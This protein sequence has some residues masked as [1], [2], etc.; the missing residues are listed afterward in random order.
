VEYTDILLA[1]TRHLLE[2]VRAADPTPVVSWLRDRVKALE[3]IMKMDISLSDPKAEVSIHQF[4][5]ITASI[6]TQ[7]TQRAKLRDEL[8]PHTEN[9]VAALN[10]FIADAR[11]RLVLIAD[12]LE[13]VTLITRDRNRTNHDEIFIDRSEQLRGLNCHVI[14]TVPISLA[15][16]SRAS[17]LMEIY[18][19]HP[20]VLP[21]VMV[22]SQDDQ[23]YGAGLATMKEIVRSRIKSVSKLKNAAL[24]PEVF[25]T[26]EILEQLC[27]ISGGHVR[28]L[29]LLMRTTIQYQDAEKLPITADDLRQ[30]IRQLRATY[31]ITVNAEQWALLAYVY[32]C[33]C[34]PN[35]DAHRSL[36][37]NRCLLE[38]RDE[39]TDAWHDVHP[40]L[41]DVPEFKAALAQR[42]PS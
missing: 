33:K 22:R 12:G 1:C 26:S 32:R 6:R 39:N 18:N 28:N 15:L 35:D 8:S 29:M 11:N 27:L 31:R 41:L 25:E 21:M 42:N 20:K 23:V 10:T 30:G 24:D 17:D 34:I 37:F 2:G 16:S 40:L 4:A 19:C 36:L 5:K 13:K 14:Y 7:P 38:Y 9:L 3:D